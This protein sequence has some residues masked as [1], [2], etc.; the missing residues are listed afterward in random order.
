MTKTRT[1][2]KARTKTKTVDMGTCYHKRVT[3]SSA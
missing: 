2:T 1:K 3:Q